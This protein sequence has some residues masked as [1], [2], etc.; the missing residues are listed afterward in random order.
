MASGLQARTT[1]KLEY[2][3]I[4]LE[5]ITSREK[6]VSADNFER[7]HEES[8]LFHLIGAKDSFLQEIN[9]AYELGLPFK[10]VKENTLQSKLEAKE[11]ESPALKE[12]V[13]LEAKSEVDKA[14]WLAV[15]IEL[16]NQGTHRFHMRRH[17]YKGGKHH[18]KVFLA[19]PLTG[20]QIETDIPLL[21]QEYLSKME[22]LLQNQRPTLLQESQGDV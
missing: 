22:A 1:S 18:D 21:L 12:I 5:E 17:F 8:F 19:N 7:A 6:H 13:R 10:D 2:A 20:E 9:A 15:A 14:D 3:R 11:V 16:R 4:H